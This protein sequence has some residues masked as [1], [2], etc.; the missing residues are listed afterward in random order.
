MAT[1]SPKGAETKSRILSS[2]SE[3]FHVR[4]V[5]A[6]SPDHIIEAS[7]TGKGQFYHY[8]KNKEQLVHEVFL[9]HLEKLRTGTAPVVTVV[10]SWEDLERWFQSYID[11][12]KRFGMKRACLF[13]TAANEVT[14]R[15]ESL[16]QDLLCIFQTLKTNLASFFTREKLAGRLTS[17]ADEDTLADFCIASLQGAMLIG[18]IHHNSDIAETVTAHALAHVKQF[19]RGAGTG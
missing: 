2:A 7:A 14:E 19:R 12:E 9:R 4:G 6:T 11:L 5:H 10:S 17:G 1:L 18:K 15:D 3:L 13:G 16:R 8:F